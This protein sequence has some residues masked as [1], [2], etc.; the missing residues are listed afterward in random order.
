MAQAGFAT[1]VLF[2]TVIIV[3]A[4]DLV[5]PGDMSVATALGIAGVCIVL[6]AAA[7]FYFFQKLRLDNGR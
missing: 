3:A 4:V 5:T 6:G 2:A 1:M 7:Q